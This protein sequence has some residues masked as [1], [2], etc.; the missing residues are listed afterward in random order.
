MIWEEGEFSSNI[1]VDYSFFFLWLVA[2]C[3]LYV[4]HMYC[5]SLFFKAE[6]ERANTVFAGNV[7]IPPKCD[8]PLIG[9]KAEVG[10]R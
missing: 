2:C 9:A 6:E 7:P 5:N 1:F 8:M 4:V 3:C 10:R